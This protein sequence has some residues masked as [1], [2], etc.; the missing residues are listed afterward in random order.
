VTRLVYY[1]VKT[2]A[3]PFAHPPVKLT[4]SRYTVADNS[5]NPFPLRIDTISISIWA[6]V[7]VPSACLLFRPLSP[8]PQTSSTECPPFAAR[9]FCTPV[10]SQH[11]KRAQISKERADRD[12]VNSAA[13]PERPRLGS[14]VSCRR[15]GGWVFGLCAVR[16]SLLQT[17]R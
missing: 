7:G 9:L 8:Q 3:S 5:I 12:K 10:T 2:V 6:W 11:K 4:S 1:V 13:C 16:C 14:P 17:A 15:L